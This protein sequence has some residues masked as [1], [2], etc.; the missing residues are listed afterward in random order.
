MIIWSKLKILFPKSIF[1]FLYNGSLLEKIL[2]FFLIKLFKFD[3]ILET[4]LRVAAPFRSVVEDAA[5]ADVLGT[6]D[7]LVAEI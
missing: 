4:A 6:F 1:P 7:V 3:L 5:L 2:Y